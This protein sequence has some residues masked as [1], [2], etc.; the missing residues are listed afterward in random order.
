MFTDLF[1]NFGG[2]VG[3]YGRYNA[4]GAPGLASALLTFELGNN[5]ALVWCVVRPWLHS[6]CLDESAG[7][8][9]GLGLTKAWSKFFQQSAW[10]VFGSW[11][12]LAWL[13]RC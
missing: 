6:N 7:E 3:Q 2:H 5:T 4:F 9:V 1:T 11:W 13:A 8:V 12:R 10:L